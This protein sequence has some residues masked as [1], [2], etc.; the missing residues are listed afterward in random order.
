MHQHVITIN[1]LFVDY[2]DNR[3]LGSDIYIYIYIYYILY[4]IYYKLIYLFFI[5]L[6]KLMNALKII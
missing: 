5:G 3:L 2:W 6:H 1:Q 4:I